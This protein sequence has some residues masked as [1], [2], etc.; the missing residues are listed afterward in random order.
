MRGIVTVT[1]WALNLFFFGTLLLLTIVLR[2]IPGSRAAV[3]GMLQRIVQMWARGHRR[4]TD[5]MLD[6]EWRVTGI[7]SLRPDANYLI[8]ANHV[9]WLDIPIIEDLS[10]GAAP[11]ARRCDHHLS[12]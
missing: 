5:E 11:V 6:V 9:S 10:R 2:L 4:I 12:W 8:V 7:E 3:T 1:L